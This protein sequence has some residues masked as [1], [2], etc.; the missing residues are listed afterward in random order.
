MNEF[1]PEEIDTSVFDFNLIHYYLSAETD[2]IE[3]L[4][5]YKLWYTARHVG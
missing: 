5:L 2:D 1:E 4:G 3:K